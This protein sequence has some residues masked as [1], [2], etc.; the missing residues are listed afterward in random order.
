MKIEESTSY[1]EAI[2]SSN[3]KEYMDAMRDEMDSMARHNVWELVDLPPQRKS[4][5][6]K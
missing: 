3:H 1:L 4:I 2:D 5:R 6:N